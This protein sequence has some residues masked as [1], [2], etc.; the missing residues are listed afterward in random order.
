FWTHTLPRAHREAPAIAAG[1]HRAAGVVD[2]WLRSDDDFR[3]LAPPL[4]AFLHACDVIRMSAPADGIPEGPV[5]ASNPRV[6]ALLCGRPAVGAP[7]G[8]SPEA[9][10]ALARER[11][12]ALVIVDSFRGD[13]PAAIRAWVDSRDGTLEPVFAVPGGVR[14]VRIRR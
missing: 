4:A 13:G 3:L 12:A 6:A 10:A 7:S 1:G 9:L 8:A 11:G 2:T 14:V 5:L